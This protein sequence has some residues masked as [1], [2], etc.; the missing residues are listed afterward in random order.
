MGTTA[1]CGRPKMGFPH[2]STGSTGFLRWQVRNCG[3]AET[4]KTFRTCFL[5]KIFHGRGSS[6][7]LYNYNDNNNNTVKLYVILYIGALQQALPLLSKIFK[8]FLASAEH[9]YSFRTSA[10]PH[11]AYKTAC[12]AALVVRKVHFRLSALE[13]RQEKI[14]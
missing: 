4:P 9:F 6:T 11:L 5:E 10:L 13:E 3:T 8:N 12:R 14:A 2:C 7:S 1:K